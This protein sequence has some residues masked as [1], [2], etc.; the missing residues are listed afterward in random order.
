ML[1]SQPRFPIPPPLLNSTHAEY[2]EHKPATG[3]R[4]CP[5]SP[6]PPAA[7]CPLPAARRPPPRPAARAPWLLRSGTG[8]SARSS[9][10][11]SATSVCKTCKVPRPRPPRRAR[12]HQAWARLV[13]PVRPGAGVAGLRRVCRAQGVGRC[14]GVCVHACACGH[15]RVCTPFPAGDHHPPPTASGSL[16]KFVRGVLGGGGPG[17]GQEKVPLCAVCAQARLKALPK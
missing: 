4:A 13:P 5:R 16:E 8:S 2:A 9:S 3:W 15:A 14:V 6:P 12:I 1:G 10:G 11:R 17:Q 7:C